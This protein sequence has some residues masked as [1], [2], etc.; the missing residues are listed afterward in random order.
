MTT[1]NQHREIGFPETVTDREFAQWDDDR[2]KAK[3]EYY[4]WKESMT[5][6]ERG[7]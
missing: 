4:A 3:E 6:D 1:T 2:E 7:I 5:D